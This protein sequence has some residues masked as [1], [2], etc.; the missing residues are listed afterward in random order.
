MLHKVIKKQYITK[1]CFVC[2]KDNETSIKARFYE[3]DNGEVAVLFDPSEEYQGYPD[4][5]H[6]GVAAT[7]LDELIGRAIIVREPGVWGVTVE[8][9]IKFKKPVPMGKPLKA[10]GRVTINRSRMFE[11]TAELLLE[12]GSTAVSAWGKYIK[13]PFDKLK[14]N[15]QSADNFII[16][17][18]KD[19]VEEVDY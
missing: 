8:L 18:Y 17:D 19:D 2:G 3:L 7:V 16:Y 6:G 14:P 11:G 12:D 13:S 5:L 9:N 1:N 15:E 4:R 10:V